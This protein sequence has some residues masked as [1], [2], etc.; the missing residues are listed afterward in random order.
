M[1]VNEKPFFQG[2][3][4]TGII[5]DVFFGFISIMMT[6]GLLNRAY[7]S[8]RGIPLNMDGTFKPYVPWLYYGIDY[9]GPKGEVIYNR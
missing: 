1:F 5:F 7:C 6:W 4:G 8:I 9:Y 2:Y 3:F